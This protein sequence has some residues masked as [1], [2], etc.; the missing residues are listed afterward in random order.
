MTASVHFFEW[1][2][3]SVQDRFEQWVESDEGQAVYEN[4]RARALRLR[5]R[6]WTH[7]GMKAIWE[8]ARY[9]RA[10]QVGPDAAGF[11]LN[12]N[13]HSRLARRLMEDEPRL[14]GFFETRVLKA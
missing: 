13:H 8:A 9:D 11:K 4:V 14:R 7:F 10:L 2:R 1:H 5:E 6:G 3:D 12:N